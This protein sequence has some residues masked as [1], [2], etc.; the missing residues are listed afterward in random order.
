MACYLPPVRLSS[1]VGFLLL[2]DGGV[3]EST[4]SRGGQGRKESNG[5]STISTETHGSARTLVG[6]S[7]WRINSS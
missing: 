3:L 7:A 2:R 1:A 5:T 6:I 4:E